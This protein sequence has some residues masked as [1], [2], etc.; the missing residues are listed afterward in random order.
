MAALASLA[1]LAPE[2]L[3]VR[4]NDDQEKLEAIILEA[5]EERHNEFDHLAVKI[6]NRIREVLDKSFRGS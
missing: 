4:W 1:G 6:A 2:F 5:R 3:A